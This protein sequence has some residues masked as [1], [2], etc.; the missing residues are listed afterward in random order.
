MTQDGRS[1]DGAAAAAPPPRVERAID[2]WVEREVPAQ[3]APAPRALHADQPESGLLGVLSGGV[4]VT[5]EGRS[6]E[7]RPGTV[8]T[9]RLGPALAW[10]AR[11]DTRVRWSA[12]P[13][14]LEAGEVAS[15]T[16]DLAVEVPAET[17]VP[18]RR[19]RRGAL[20]AT[21]IALSWAV[22][23]LVAWC[24]D[25]AHARHETAASPASTAGLPRLSEADGRARADAVDRSF[26][27]H[28]WT[29]QTKPTRAPALV[30]VH[31]FEP[32]R[33]RA[34][35][36]VLAERLRPA[37]AEAFRVATAATRTVQVSAHDAGTPWGNLTFSRDGKVG[38]MW[39][40]GGAG[41]AAETV[42]TAGA[43]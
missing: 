10:S 13:V 4:T 25:R 18:S 22:A 37:V 11:P 31:L 8:V 38:T 42:S 16:S 23:L 43:R 19:R 34:D 7:V 27:A 5:R 36:D 40:R 35:L 39:F 17:A 6:R 33:D 14:R 2:P 1:R 3:P 20:A 24:Y 32:A 15:W 28:G 9:Y 21:A 30:L 41:A 29:A 26:R 12:R